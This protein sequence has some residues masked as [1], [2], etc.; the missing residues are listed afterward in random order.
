MC[1]VCIWCTASTVLTTVRVFVAGPAGVT[2]AELQSSSV[3]GGQRSVPTN[4]E[5]LAKRRKLT[6]EVATES[7]LYSQT[8]TVSISLDE[9][10]GQTVSHSRV[11]L[12]YTSC[13]TF[14][15]TCCLCFLLA[16]DTTHWL[17]QCRM[18]SVLCSSHAYMC[19]VLWNLFNPDYTTHTIS[20]CP[21][22]LAVTLHMCSM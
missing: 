6:E 16:K 12:C 22:T 18:N 19:D 7:N 3:D 17:V 1:C 10:Q 9:Y 8:Q 4:V 2:V 13:T 21:L 20:S 5:P 11:H 14:Y 15:C